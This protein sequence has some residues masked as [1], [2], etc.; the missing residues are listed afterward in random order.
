MKVTLAYIYKKFKFSEKY[1]GLIYKYTQFY[2][3]RPI[4]N[5]QYNKKYIISLHW[6]EESDLSDYTLWKMR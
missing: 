5:L 4:V 1:T 3:H 2:W 6:K